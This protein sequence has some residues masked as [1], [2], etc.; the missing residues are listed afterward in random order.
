VK[1]YLSQNTIDVENIACFSSFSKHHNHL[2]AGDKSG[3][4]YLLD[5]AK[6]IVFSKKELSIGRRVLYIS[7]TFINDGDVS[8]TT[9]AVVLNSHNKIYIL[10]YKHA[11]PKLVITHQI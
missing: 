1:E 6:K 11:E 7:E 4:V 10:R 5:L 9:L 8:I 3:S 2:L